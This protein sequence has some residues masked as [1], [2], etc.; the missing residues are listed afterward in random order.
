[1]KSGSDKYKK[2]LNL[3]RHSSPKLDGIETIEE[4]IMGRLRSKDSMHRSFPDLIETLFSWTYI[5][6]VRRS[7][8]TASILL[9]LFFIYQQ[10]VILKGVNDINKRA[11]TGRTESFP[12][13]GYSIGKQL[14]ILRLTGRKIATSDLEFS[15]RQIEQLIDSYN[16]LEEKY[17]D[18]VRIIDEDPVLKEYIEM[19]LKADRNNKPNL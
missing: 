15:G 9:V 10:S 16:E 5:S 13:P 11:I 8:V 14:M 4:N 6:W 3:L 17:S 2:V 18:L 7:L 1:M 12:V 19:K